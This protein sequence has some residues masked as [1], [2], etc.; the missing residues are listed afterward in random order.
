M[1]ALLSNI[2]GCY[3]SLINYYVSKS[4]S[5]V[6]QEVALGRA[7][8]CQASIKHQEKRIADLKRVLNDLRFQE[9]NL[10]ADIKSVE[11]QIDEKCRLYYPPEPEPHKP[12]TE[13]QMK[14]I[15]L[16]GKFN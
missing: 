15:P 14:Y 10:T 5:L 7:I 4:K 6:G 3:A 11:N 13:D 16:T 12:P 9:T 2:E 8:N 1:A